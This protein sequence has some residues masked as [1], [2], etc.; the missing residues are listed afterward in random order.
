M[1]TFNSNIIWTRKSFSS[2]LAIYFIDIMTNMVKEDGE[3]GE[4]KHRVPDITFL[5]RLQF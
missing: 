5:I 1:I 4:D 3:C 2:L